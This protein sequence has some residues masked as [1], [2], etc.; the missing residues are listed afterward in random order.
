MG[1]V[2]TRAGI[3]RIRCRAMSR[4]NRM[5]N[6]GRNFATKN[7]RRWQV[8]HAYVVN[9]DV[10]TCLSYLTPRSVLTCFCSC[11]EACTR[12][13][14]YGSVYKEKK[15]QPFDALEKAFLEEF[16]LPPNSFPV[17]QEA[18]LS[19]EVCFPTYLWCRTVADSFLSCILFCFIQFRV[20]AFNRH[21]KVG[22][23]DGIS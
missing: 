23:E 19:G 3:E 7:T 20:N 13:C 5:N 15:G 12:L 9:E 10:V 4:M 6:P 11:A 14:T 18:A 22:T 2:V 16:R 8:Q 17:S 1:R 21:K